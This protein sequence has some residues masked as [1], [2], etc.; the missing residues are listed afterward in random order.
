MMFFMS[1][2]YFAMVFCPRP[3][4]R[5]RRV[6]PGHLGYERDMDI[7]DLLQ[8]FCG[9]LQ[10]FNG[11]YSDFVGY[12]RFFLGGGQLFNGIYSDLMGYERGKSGLYSEVL[13]GFTFGHQTWLAGKKTANFL[14]FPAGNLHLVRTYSIMFDD[15]GGYMFSLLP[16]P[17][18]PQAMGL[19]AEKL[20]LW[21]Y[22]H[23]DKSA[24]ICPL[25]WVSNHDR[26]IGWI[27]RTNKHV[28]KGRSTSSITVS[29]FMFSS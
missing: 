26:L 22:D 11:I 14:I 9:I 15:T 5:H 10:W 28:H 7:V 17:S 16:D 1:Y 23:Q 12:Y 25:D 21:L 18:R 20:C 19:I 3:R 8:W 2:P 6:G 13:K 27:L 29:S 24:S 4:P